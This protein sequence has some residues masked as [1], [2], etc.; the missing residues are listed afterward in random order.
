MDHG[1]LI[2]ASAGIGIVA[3]VISL[4]F[5]IRNSVAIK[6]INRRTQYMK[7]IDDFYQMKNFGDNLY[8]TSVNFEFTNYD[9]S[10]RYF[11]EEL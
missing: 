5:Q 9:E 11:F 3:L 4:I 7:R 2:Q 6:K 10:N 1:I 8:D